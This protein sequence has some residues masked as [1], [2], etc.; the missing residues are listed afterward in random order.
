MVDRLK[1]DML[2]RSNRNPAFKVVEKNDA[3]H[4]YYAYICY[5]AAPPDAQEIPV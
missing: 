1:N 4:S 5:G 3:D 2:P